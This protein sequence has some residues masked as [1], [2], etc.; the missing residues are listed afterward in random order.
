MAP[1]LGRMPQ[2][3]TA[4]P[5]GSLKI[6]RY[7][8]LNLAVSGASVK[9]CFCFQHGHACKA[10]SLLMLMWWPRFQTLPGLLS[11]TKASS[12]ISASFGL[13]CSFLYLL[14]HFENKHSRAQDIIGDYVGLVQGFASK[15]GTIL[16][17]FLGQRA[18]FEAQADPSSHLVCAS[19]CAALHSPTEVYKG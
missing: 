18:L 5:L 15:G 14:I 16:A 2:S 12:Q 8:F 9:R 10:H 4:M 13:S 19:H 7:I 6:A 17:W 1:K 3:G 11:P